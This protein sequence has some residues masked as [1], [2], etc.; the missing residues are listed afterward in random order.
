MREVH[1]IDKNLVFPVL[2]Y[3]G[4]IFGSN[5]QQVICFPH[6]RNRLIIYYILVEKVDSECC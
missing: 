2:G 3:H 4:Q 6:S 1:E 5:G